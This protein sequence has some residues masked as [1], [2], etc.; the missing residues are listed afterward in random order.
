M[1]DITLKVPKTSCGHCKDAIEGELNKLCG[2]E[3]SNVNLEDGT[4]KVYY[5]GRVSEEQLKGGV[6]G[7]GYAVTA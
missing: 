2:V 6:E 5:D 1:T 4:L 7:A 3:Y